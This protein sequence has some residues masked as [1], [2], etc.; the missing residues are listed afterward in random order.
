MTQTL[1]FK[2]FLEVSVFS[3]FSVKWSCLLWTGIKNLKA[4]F[5]QERALF[6]NWCFYSGSKAP[7]NFSKSDLES[8]AYIQTEHMV[9]ITHPVRHS[10]PISWGQTLQGPFVMVRPNPGALPSGHPGAILPDWSSAASWTIC[11]SATEPVGL[12]IVVEVQLIFRILA[13]YRCFGRG[14]FLLWWAVQLLV[15]IQF[16]LLEGQKVK[17]EEWKTWMNLSEGAKSVSI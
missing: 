16:W 13:D 14:G 1:N 4:E 3:F 2:C 7:S 12:Q 6:N 11:I 10:V 15:W 5:F 9:W 8:Y 17:N